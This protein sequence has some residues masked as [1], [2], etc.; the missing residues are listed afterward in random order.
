MIQYGSSDK[1]VHVLL[2]EDNLL[3][4]EAIRIML[5]QRG[6][7]VSLAKN[8]QDAVAKMKKQD[9]DLLLMAIQK[10]VPGAVDATRE[11][12]QFNIYT[13]IIAFTSHDDT[14]MLPLIKE[15]G[16]NGFLSK[17]ASPEHICDTLLQH[18]HSV[19]RYS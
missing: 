10:S 12:R 16:M 5:S 3:L 7:Q 19:K 18:A 6:F 8:I 13:P 14:K 2:A 1:P 9:F 4:Q 17:Y 15:A 11:I